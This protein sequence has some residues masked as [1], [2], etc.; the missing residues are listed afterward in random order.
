V[1]EF[2]EFYLKNVKTLAQEVKYVPLADTAYTMA[3][4]RFRNKQTGS[5]F[6]GIPE[7]GLAIEEL[8]RRAPKA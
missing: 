8:L 6:G 4:E 7:V 2:V 5:G 3:M 1:H